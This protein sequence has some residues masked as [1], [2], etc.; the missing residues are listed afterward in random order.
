MCRLATNHNG[1]VDF[2]RLVFAVCPLSLQRGWYEV[3][4]AKLFLNKV[5]TTASL[6][7]KSTVQREQLE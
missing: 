3:V 7:E 4:P 2:L 5:L 6:L 1:F